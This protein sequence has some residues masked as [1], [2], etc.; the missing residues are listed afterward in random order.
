[1][2]IPSKVI[3]LLYVRRY[4]VVIWVLDG[5]VDGEL[6]CCTGGNE[7]KLEGEIENSQHHVSCAST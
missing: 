1:M 3:D 5:V 6:T 7:V 4:P 2:C